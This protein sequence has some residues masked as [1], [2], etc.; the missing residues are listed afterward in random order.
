MSI[1]CISCNSAIGL[2]CGRGVEKLI[3]YKECSS[4]D[5]L[6]CGACWGTLVPSLSSSLQFSC[7]KCP[8]TSTSHV[9]Q[10]LEVS[11][12]FSTPIDLLNKFGELI[13]IKSLLE[14]RSE[15]W[16]PTDAAGAHTLKQLE[17]LIIRRTSVEHVNVTCERI[18]ESDYTMLVVKGSRMKL[19]TVISGEPPL[20]TVTSLLRDLFKSSERNYRMFKVTGWRGDPLESDG[21]WSCERRDGSFY[22]TILNPSMV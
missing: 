2:S 7:R 19:R 12:E 9:R 6:I 8:I 18:G 17:R 1:K 20:R 16:F 22:I 4:C 13:P 3:P 15:K 10:F 21:E 14:S 11:K 5:S